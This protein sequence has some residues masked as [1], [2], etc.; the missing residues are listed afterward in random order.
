MA[1]EGAVTGGGSDLTKQLGKKIGPLPLG[2]WLVIGGVVVWYVWK[3]QKASGS[4]S[5][6]STD[7]AGNVGTI[8]PATGYVYGSSQDTAA[9]SAGTDTGAGSTSTGVTSGSTTA[10]TY[11]DNNAWA[12]AA[13]NYLVGLGVDPSVAN[14][15]VQ[16][17]LASQVLTPEQQ[18]D[19]N[20]A[21]QGIGSPPTLPGPIG[22]APASLTSPAS[23]GNG[24]TVTAS[25][26]PSGLVATPASTSVSL[27]WGSVTNA[28][29][30]TVAYGTT[31]AAS[32]GTQTVTGTSAT[33]G[34]LNP[35]TLYYFTVQATPAKTGDAHAS[36]TATT[37]KSSGTAATQASTLPPG[38][39]W[40]DTASSS[41]T[42]DSIARRFGI[43]VASL[44]SYNGW[45]GTTGSTKIPPNT[46]VKVRSDAG[47]F[48]AAAYKA[49]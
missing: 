18:G 35:G 3:R 6:A 28:T 48:N 4:G 33:V 32:D 38:Y 30:Y 40:F 44:A 49:L 9:L 17:F 47:P 20:L 23:P 22:T 27:L 13:I 29:G 41:Y 46:H 10:G 12:R 15:A 19:V 36:T 39:G 7:S 37:L 31:S 16:Q 5:G 1:E 8:D 25:N 11:A 14:E 43:S 2:A 24:T 34:G 21:I 45:S 26:P 42:A